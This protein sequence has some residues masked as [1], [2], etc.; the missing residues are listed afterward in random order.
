[1]SALPPNNQNAMF[2][3]IKTLLG[4]FAAAMR[5]IDNS[6]PVRLGKEYTLAGDE[7]NPKNTAGFLQTM[8][9]PETAP[10]ADTLLQFANL[11][12]TG[13]P[14][15][16]NLAALTEIPGPTR[17]TLEAMGKLKS[18]LENGL[19]SISNHNKKILRKNSTTVVKQIIPLLKGDKFVIKLVYNLAAMGVLTVASWLL[20]TSKE[21]GWKIGSWGVVVM[22]FIR[23]LGNLL[24]NNFDAA[25]QAWTM[26]YVHVGLGIVGYALEIAKRAG[27]TPV[28]NTATILRN[29]FLTLIPVGVFYFDDLRNAVEN[30]LYKRKRKGSG[31]ASAEDVN[32]LQPILNVLQTYLDTSKDALNDSSSNK[33]GNRTKKVALNAQAAVQQLFGHLKL[34]VDPET[35]R[36]WKE[37]FVF[38]ARRAAINAPSVSYALFTGIFLLV[39]AQNDPQALSDATVLVLILSIELVLGIGDEHMAPDQLAYRMILLT[40]GRFFSIFFY[41]APKIHHLIHT[42]GHTNLFN[43]D[44][45]LAAILAHLG[46]F[47]LCTFGLGVIPTFKLF[48]TGTKWAFKKVARNQQHQTD[49]KL[50]CPTTVL[51]IPVQ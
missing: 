41:A 46:A 43:E 8:G 35:Q 21:K 10:E 51:S 19:T 38:L 28:Q 9:I 30:L 5:T 32:A 18:L 45:Q 33:P 23:L 3:G 14:D 36:S 4:K 34:S 15:E 16:I 17:P 2:N 42:G 26:T 31:P 47:V 48:V 29:F 25:K 22:G 39:A 24:Y 7:L 44:P 11:T 40:L 37:T 12:A 50:E 1:M 49:I 27:Y 20:W 13:T 6:V